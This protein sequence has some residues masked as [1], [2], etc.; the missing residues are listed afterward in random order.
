MNEVS[1]ISAE[2]DR[3]LCLQHKGTILVVDDQPALLKVAQILLSRCGYRVITAQD[4]QEAKIKA[5]QNPNID[6]LLTDVEMPGMLGDEMAEWFQKANPRAGVIF[7]SGNSMQRLR[8]K[9]FPCIEKPFVHLDA[10]VRII[11][12]SL[13]RNCAVRNATTA[14][15]A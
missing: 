11:R 2:T 5:R 7:M 6:L 4:G 9:D 13:A 12:K 1:N 3:I 14:A 8:L 15:A 10:W